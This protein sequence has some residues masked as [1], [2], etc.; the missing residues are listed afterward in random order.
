MKYE[1][2]IYSSLRVI[3]KVKVFVH[4]HADTDARGFDNSSPD[5]RPSG[6]KNDKQD[7]IV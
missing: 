1:S 2:S 7:Y 6:I 5:I 3:G 4:T